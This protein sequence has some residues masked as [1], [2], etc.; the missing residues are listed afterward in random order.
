M[1]VAMGHDRR[2]GKA[3]EDG[4][5]GSFL[6]QAA[7]KMAHPIII[8]LHTGSDILIIE[9]TLPAAMAH[10]ICLYQLIPP[11]YQLSG[12]IF[13][14]FQHAGMSGVQGVQAVYRRQYFPFFI[15]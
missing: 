8:S 12:H 3:D 13:H 10:K 4:I 15:P 11:L 1:P 7:Y 14:I 5:A 6:R 9:N 2:D